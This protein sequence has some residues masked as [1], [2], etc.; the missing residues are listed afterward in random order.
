[1][2]VLKLSIVL[3]TL[4]SLHAC[5]TVYEQQSDCLSKDWFAAGFDTAKRGS[6]ADG[7]WHSVSE[8]CTKQNVWVDRGAYDHGH[9]LGLE[10][11]CTEI[12]GFEFGQRNLS[13][14]QI[15]ATEPQA[16]FNRAFTDGQYLHSESGNLEYAEGEL[17]A[18]INEADYARDRRYELRDLI[19][20]ADLDDATKKQYVKER[21]RLKQGLYGSERRISNLQAKVNEI[22]R[23]YEKLE[24]RL[25]D[26]YYSGDEG[27]AADFSL[28]ES[29]S[30]DNIVVIR[31]AIIVYKPSGMSK[32]VKKHFNAVTKEINKVITENH[33]GRFR[34][35][36]VG[37]LNIEFVASQEK[38]DS[39]DPAARYSTPTLLFWN[40][41]RVLKS[42]P[43]DNKPVEE[44][45]ALVDEFAR[46]N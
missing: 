9:K 18:E 27:R 17:S 14:E 31:P 2:R 28:D 33:S 16:L 43:Y 5:T 11:F 7:S 6:D 23:R 46:S 10:S 3:L 32:D 13:Y 24:F 15:C 36:M 34:Y 4:L 26:K 44:L 30:R 39:V 19:D 1:M 42:V 12:N 20:N 29:V 25:F 41:K 21:Y 8:E 35:Q 40:T 22:Q 38:V 45:I 37:D